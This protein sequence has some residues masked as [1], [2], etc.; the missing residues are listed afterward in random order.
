MHRPRRRL[1]LIYHLFEEMRLHIEKRAGRASATHKKM[2]FPARRDSWL[3]YSRFMKIS[4]EKEVKIGIFSNRNGIF[5]ARN[6]A[7]KGGK[8]TFPPRSGLIPR[9]FAPNSTLCT[10]TKVEKSYFFLKFPAKYLHNNQ[11]VI[12]FVM[13][14]KTNTMKPKTKERKKI[15]H[16]L[17]FYLQL[18]NELKDRDGVLQTILYIDEEI[19]KL[20]ELLKM[21]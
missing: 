4:P 9:A 20:V 3:I 17:L 10:S 18:Y 21:M 16:R 5:T 1:S 19:A 12:I 13:S 8:R 14:I 7:K 15:E 6:S 11:K 2:I